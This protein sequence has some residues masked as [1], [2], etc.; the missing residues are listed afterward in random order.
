VSASRSGH[1]DAFYVGLDAG[2]HF[3]KYQLPDRP[4]FGAGAVFRDTVIVSYSKKD[5]FIGKGS[6]SVS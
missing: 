4:I 5:L 1:L 6:S 2:T 3:T